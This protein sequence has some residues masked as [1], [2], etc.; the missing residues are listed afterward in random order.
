MEIDRSA[1]AAGESTSI[2]PA[3]ANDKPPTPNPVSRAHL[4]GHHHHLD[5]QRDALLPLNDR[6]LRPGRPRAM[7]FCLARATPISLWA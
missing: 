1:K 6:G 7:L 5:S 2:F 4:A 3:D